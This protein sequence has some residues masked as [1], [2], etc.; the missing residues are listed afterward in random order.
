[1][2]SPACAAPRPVAVVLALEEGPERLHG[3]GAVPRHERGEREGAEAAA[4]GL[5][6]LAARRAASETS[7]VLVGCAHGG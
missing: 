3:G 7:A 2:R 4:G 5:E 1:M 6:E